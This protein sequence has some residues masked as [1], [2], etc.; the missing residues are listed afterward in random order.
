MIWFR[1]LIN[2]LI[3]IILILVLKAYQI[4]Q[5]ILVMYILIIKLLHVK[6]VLV[7]RK[8]FVEAIIKLILID[9]KQNVEV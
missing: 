5:I 6:I 9:V 2:L 8:K 1:L 3:I 7:S 4:Y